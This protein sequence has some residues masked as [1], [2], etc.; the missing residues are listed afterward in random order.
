ML[1]FPTC[2]TPKVSYGHTELL[3]LGS[4]AAP[5]RPVDS[6]SCLRY[7]QCYVQ[8]AQ[9]PSEISARG[10][11]G[12]NAAQTGQKLGGVPGRAL[13]GGV[14]KL[15]ELFPELRQDK[16]LSSSDQDKSPILNQCMESSPCMSNPTNQLKAGVSMETS[17]KRALCRSTGDPAPLRFT[18]EPEEKV[19]LRF[20]TVR[21]VTPSVIPI[22]PVILDYGGIRKAARLS[23]V[24]GLSATV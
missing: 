20:W 19:P 22:T 11:C 23:Q 24:R 17:D 10:G 18:R 4:R 6:F 5:T 3:T 7:T 8:N 14:R 21:T 2:V 12:K 1:L 13:K 15:S 16:C 9:F